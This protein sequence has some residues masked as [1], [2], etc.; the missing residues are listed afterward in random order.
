MAAAVARAVS[1]ARAHQHDHAFRVRRAVIVEQVVLPSG[2]RGETVH[3][4]LH[5]LRHAR[6]E[7][8]DRL[9]RLEERVGVVCRAAYHRA[10]RRSAPARDAH[11]PGR[12][13]SWRG[14]ARRSAARWWRARARC[15]T[16]R[17]NA[18][19]GCATAS[20]AACAISAAVMRLLHRADDSM[21]KPVVRAAMTSEW[22]PKIDSACVARARAA[23]WNTVGVSSPAI[24][25]MLGS[26][27]S[28]PCDAV[29]VVVSA[30]DCSAPCTVPA[31]PPSLCISCTTGTLP[32]MF[33]KPFGRPFVGQLRHRRGRRDREDRAD[34]VHPVGDM[35]HRGVAVHHGAHVR[36]STAA[37]RIGHPA[38]AGTRHGPVAPWP[39]LCGFGDHLDRV[40]W[41]LLEA[42]AA[43]GARRVVDAVAQ[44][45]PELGDRLLRARG[46]A[47]VAFEAVAAGQAA[48]RLVPCLG[49]LSPASTSSKPDI[50]AAS[51]SAA[52][53]P[54]RRR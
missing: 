35:R 47:V 51:A 8:V 7:R 50:R 40:A 39:P 34:L 6:V 52:A 31:A 18:G 33:G 46:I 20:V 9:A 3:L 37:P 4:P 14:S 42:H 36:A 27:S 26:I 24:L 32:Q 12:R 23:M 15:G 17:R 19:T 11:A 45:R 2:Q 54:D 16:R 53:P 10:L 41:A 48:L 49:S 1:A 22:S 5:D 21:A 28:R 44:A 38:T 13:R 25:N 30:P 29:N 43:A